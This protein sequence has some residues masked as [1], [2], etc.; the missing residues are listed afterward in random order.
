MGSGGGGICKRCSSHSA[1]QDPGL[2]AALGHRDPLE[3]LQYPW[4]QCCAAVPVLCHLSQTDPSCGEFVCVPFK[5]FCHSPAEWGVLALTKQEKDR[6]IQPMCPADLSSVLQGQ[7]LPVLVGLCPPGSFHMLVAA[8]GGTDCGTVG[9]GWTQTAQTPRTLTVVTA[10]PPAVA[11]FRSQ[12]P[13]S[14][15]LWPHSPLRRLPHIVPAPRSVKPAGHR[16]SRAFLEGL[17]WKQA[18]GQAAHTGQSGEHCLGFPVPPNSPSQAGEVTV[19]RLV[20]SR[21]WSP[22]AQWF[23]WL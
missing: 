3:A 21:L 5:S 20:G 2:G 14:R 13:L 9:H 12:A 4:G 19:G 15:D 8:R 10:L 17:L 11:D 1:R 7:I 16:G 22:C 23:L 6:D 18:L